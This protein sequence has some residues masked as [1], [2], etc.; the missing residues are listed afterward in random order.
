MKKKCI[1]ALALALVLAAAPVMS[2]AA[3]GSPSYDNDSDSGSSSSSSSSGSSSSSS[4]SSGSY[5]GGNGTSGTSVTAPTSPSVVVSS[6][7]AQVSVGQASKD[8]TG[9][10]MSLVVNTTTADGKSVTMGDNGAAIVGDVEIFMAVGD[11]ETAGL[12]EATVSM[13]NR[14][15]GGESAASVFPGS[16]LEGYSKIG[17]TRALILSSQT[18]GTAAPAAAEVSLLVSDLNAGAQSVVVMYYDNA[19]G[20]WIKADAVFNAA[21]KLVTFK[22]PGSCTVQILWK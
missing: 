13:I 12:P 7:G 17:N 18:A 4:S 3:S 1:K 15:N 8:S 16:G 9:T 21:T 5:T 6:N 22:A 14:L 11:A 10:S 19:T 20:Q 2:Y